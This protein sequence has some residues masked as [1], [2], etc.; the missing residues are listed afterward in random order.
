M[1]LS[2]WISWLLSSGILVINLLVASKMV[3]DIVLE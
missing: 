1:S 3:F 2:R